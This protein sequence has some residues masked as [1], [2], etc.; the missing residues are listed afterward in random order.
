M[1]ILIIARTNW[2]EP[3]RIRHQICNMLLSHGHEVVFLQ[4]PNQKILSDLELSKNQD[5]LVLG[6][7]P[8]LVHH[9]LR[10]TRLID[11]VNERFVISKL[12]KFLIE[13]NFD[14]ILNFN[15]DYGFLKDYAPSGRFITI[16][17]DDFVAAARPWMTNSVR[18][19]IKYTSRVSDAVLAVSYP[20]YDFVKK[21]NNRSELFFPWC[22]D[23][24]VYPET[25]V[26]RNVVL[27]FGYINDRIDWGDV[28]YL[29]SRDVNLRFVG[30]VAGSKSKK[31]IESFKG[32]SNFEI[33][34]PVSFDN[35][36]LGDVFCSIAPY[37]KSIESVRACTVSNRAFRLLSHGIPMIY[38]DLP[39]LIDAGDNVISKAID[40]EGYLDS[41]RHFEKH[42]YACQNHIE[43]FLVGN[44]ESDR[45]EVLSRIAGW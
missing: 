26:T 21:Y 32:F 44:Y 20:L 41:I 28:E 13:G 45:Y 19:K 17:N 22:E 10:L 11:W 43:E 23:S 42:F 16:I 2:V 6:E 18:E 3:P 40:K 14:L 27:Y 36:Y 35:L 31:A 1:R 4:K 15:Y 38:P 5:G 12:K 24:Y 37:D 39:Y 34:E 7:Y 29:L 33:R 30:P 25:G 9:Q 8:E